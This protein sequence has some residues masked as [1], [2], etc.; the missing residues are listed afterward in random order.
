M[1]GQGIAMNRSI[2]QIPLLTGGAGRLPALDG[3]RGIAILLVLLY[4]FA[5]Y[6][7]MSPV[8]AVD[9]VVHAIASA[10][11]VGV[12]LFFVLS[13]FLITGIL[14]DAK[15]SK[16]FFRNFYMRRT[17]R[18]FP[19]YYGFLIVFF[20][21]FPHILAPNEHYQAL[22]QEQAW[23]WTYLTNVQIAMKGWPPDYAI[24]HFWSLALEE[25]FYLIWPLTVFF[26]GRRQLMAIC[27]AAIAASLAVRL[28]LRL[29]DN[30]TAAYVLTLARMDTLAVGALVALIAR[31][32]GEFTKMA[33][34]ARP[35]A[36]AAGLTLATYLVV[37]RPLDPE[38][39]LMQ[40][41]GYPLLAV[42]FAAVLVI[43][44]TAPEGGTI[45][46]FF[47]YPALAFFGH[48]SYAIYVFHHPLIYYIQQTGFRVSKL[49]KVAGSQLAGLILYSGV[50]TGITVVLAMLSWHLFESHVLK[51]KRFFSYHTSRPAPVAENYEVSKVQG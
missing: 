10:G 47:A 29:A 26:F 13:G 30:P 3:L 48:Y 4:H 12:D 25:Q 9:Q 31:E 8:I 45:A 20:L 22:V 5:L 14:C 50:V 44:L 40:L 36:L 51:L 18:I 46:K 6:G 37:K 21:V 34:W 33:R 28:G 42:F 43:G 2:T 35:A 11:W 1:P 7:G 27:A 32:P 49:P 41:Y 38:D 23:Y 17:L 19:L 16:H 39:M 24:G 15:G